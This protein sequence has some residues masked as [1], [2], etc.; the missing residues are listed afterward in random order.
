MVAASLAAILRECILISSNGSLHP[1]LEFRCNTRNREDTKSIKT[2][3]GGLLMNSWYCIYTKSNYEDPLCQ[4][5][6][7]FTDIELFNPKLKRKKYV[8]GKLTMVVEALFPCYVFARFDLLHYYHMI[9][10]TRGVR[11]I[12]GNSLGY[13]KAVD[14]AIVHMIKLKAPDGYISFEQPKF[15]KG[16]KLII[17]GGPFEGFIGLFMEELKPRDRILILLNTLKYEASI[18][19]CRDFVVRYDSA[20]AI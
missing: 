1:T 14:D 2:Q 8:R 10:Y 19:V 16:D 9:K 17:K 4:R 6:S 15:S 13:P 5:L 3:H 11:R 7:E 12:I 20:L 18:E